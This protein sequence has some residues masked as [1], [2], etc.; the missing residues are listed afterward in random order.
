MRKNIVILKCINHDYVALDG[1][2]SRCTCKDI[3]EN[4]NF[5]YVVYKFNSI[6]EDL[7]FKISVKI[8][9]TFQINFKSKI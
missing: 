6:C 4:L 5:K 3:S 8:L 2:V 1:S 9:T 7:C